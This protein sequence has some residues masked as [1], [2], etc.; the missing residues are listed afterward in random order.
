MVKGAK[1][2][3]V[4]LASLVQGPAGTT[5]LRGEIGLEE[6]M[7][8]EAEVVTGEVAAAEIVVAR[9]KVAEDAPV[10]IAGKKSS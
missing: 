9:G 4:S 7:E 6:A 1:A 8:E 10:G 5:D 2:S 3:L